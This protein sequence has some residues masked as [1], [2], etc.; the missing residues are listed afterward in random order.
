MT[1]D[2]IKELREAMERLG[3]LKGTREQQLTCAV[4]ECLDEIERLS[5]MPTGGEL[6]SEA[7]DIIGEHA[8]GYSVWL[9]AAGGRSFPDWNWDPPALELERIQRVRDP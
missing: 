1:P 3:P 6:L 5:S 8:P 4:G 2:R 9:E 7:Y